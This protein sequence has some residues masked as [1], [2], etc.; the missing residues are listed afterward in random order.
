MR[1]LRLLSTTA[2]ILA[3]L[4]GTS[5]AVIAQP[6]RTT[7]DEPTGHWI[8]EPVLSVIEAIPNRTT[9]LGYAITDVFT[10]SL[11]GQQ[12]QF[13]QKG[14]INLVASEDG[15]RVQVSPLGE[16]MYVP[17]VVSPIYN[18]HDPTCQMFNTGYAVCYEFLDYYLQNSGERIFG[19]PISPIEEIDGRM[20]QYF[21]AARL[22]YWF[23]LPA[24][25]RIVVT[26]L[27]SRY[28][29]MMNYS[30]ML[31]KPNPAKA[32]LLTPQKLHITASVVQTLI[33]SSES[34]TIQIIAQD[35]YLQPLE[36]VVL[37]LTLELG[38]GLEL[39]Y[40]AGTTNAQ[41]ICTLTL[42]APDLPPNSLVSVRIR[43]VTPQGTEATT[44]T[45][46]R[47]WW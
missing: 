36:G 39:F 4:A 7:F 46:F 12:V 31:L 20:V 11:T 17:G 16:I 28:F 18:P 24:G 25:E 34:Q 27:G 30:P 37:S 47:I 44:R 14:R 43:A 41:G 26:D 8:A 10:D 40:P 38:S 42:P 23:D 22:E 32:Q 3:L 29:E 6:D 1:T 5:S 33:G 19:L 21:H 9:N 35:A 15:M 13:F 2:L 45:S